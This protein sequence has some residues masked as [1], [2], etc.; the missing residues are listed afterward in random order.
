MKAIIR[1]VKV[2]EV[3]VG[4]FQQKDTGEVIEYGNIVQDGGLVDVKWKLP[5]HMREQ[6]EKDLESGYTIDL[7]MDLKF[8]NGK[9][10]FDTVSGYKVK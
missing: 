2:K 3:K 8:N 10:E 1:G 6:A 9:I 5:K 7:E 4:S